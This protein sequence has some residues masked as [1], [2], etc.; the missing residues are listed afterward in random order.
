MAAQR[1][2]DNSRLCE[3]ADCSFCW[4]VVMWP[5]RS[6]PCTAVYEWPRSR[7]CIT[8]SS[9]RSVIARHGGG[10]R[11]RPS[12][13]ACD[14]S[15]RME[16]SYF[17]LIFSHVCPQRV[18]TDLEGRRREHRRQTSVFCHSV[19]RICRLPVGHSTCDRQL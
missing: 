6:N 9:S 10:T 18:V 8:W 11:S 4:R 16:G 3:P 14:R 7:R 12:S 5:S 2:A 13:Y 1:C 15:G 19:E 17:F